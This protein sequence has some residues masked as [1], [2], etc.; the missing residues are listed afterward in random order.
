MNDLRRGDG[1]S[2]PC[3]DGQ[4]G[5]V[6]SEEAEYFDSWMAID[7]M[8]DAL[9]ALCASESRGFAAGLCSAFYMCGV[10]D[11]AEWRHFMARISARGWWGPG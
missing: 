3:A 4:T 11:N 9:T 10:L 5:R 7:V 6:V 8:E 1:D 2:A